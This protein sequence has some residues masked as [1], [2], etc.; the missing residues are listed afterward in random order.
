MGHL[1]IAYSGVDVTS[2]YEFCEVAGI[3][4]ANV[5]MYWVDSMLMSYDWETTYVDRTFLEGFLTEM[6]LDYSHLTDEMWSVVLDMVDGDDIPFDTT[7]VLGLL[8]FAGVDTSNL[9]TDYIH[10]VLTENNWEWYV[11]D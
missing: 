6:Q 3:S 1:G 10:T 7:Y 5:D 2:F 9:D 4:T 11:L 8:Q